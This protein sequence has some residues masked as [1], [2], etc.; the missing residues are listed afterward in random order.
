[1]DDCEISAPAHMSKIPPYLIQGP[2]PPTPSPLADPGTVPGL[3]LGVLQ[4]KLHSTD[5]FY[6]W[7]TS[8]GTGANYEPRIKHWPY[9]VSS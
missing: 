2:F 9:C 4:E 3:Q 7:P 8:T 5:T 6:S 1:M